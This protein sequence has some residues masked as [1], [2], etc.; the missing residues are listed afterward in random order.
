MAVR[1]NP[2]LKLRIAN[3]NSKYGLRTFE[4]DPSQVRPRLHPLS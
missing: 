4:A 3:V 2:E 1:T